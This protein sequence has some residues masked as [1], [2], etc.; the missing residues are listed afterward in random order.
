MKHNIRDMEAIRALFIGL[1]EAWNNGDG[2]AYADHF[3]G[4]ADF[5]TVSG[6]YLQGRTE[7]AEAHQW[8]FNGPLKGSQLELKGSKLDSNADFDYRFLTADI[9]IIHGAGEVKLEP[10]NDSPADR[11]SINTSVVVRQNEG[12]RITAFHNC[13]VQEMQNGFPR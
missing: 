13:S 8:L 4:D 11:V 10:M 3:T 1:A 6:I 5:V 7:I 12:W 9:A 2:T